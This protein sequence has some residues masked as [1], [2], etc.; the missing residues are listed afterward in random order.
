MSRSPFPIL[1][2][3]KAPLCKGS[4]LQSR[5]RDC[6]FNPCLRHTA[7]PLALPMGEL[8][9]KLTERAFPRKARP[10]PTPSAL[11]G[12]IVKSPACQR[13]YPNP[14]EAQ[15]ENAF[16]LRGRWRL[17]RRMRWNPCLWH[18]TP[19]HYIYADAPT[20]LRSRGHLLS[21]R[22]FFPFS[23]ALSSR[24]SAS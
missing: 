12:A 18:T 4:C 22:I 2:A 21:Q 8:S 1:P 16:P 3:T 10:F 6:P 9:A 15:Q 24:S 5:L 13:Q 23:S 14:R 19:L 11:V 20:I 17:S 7:P